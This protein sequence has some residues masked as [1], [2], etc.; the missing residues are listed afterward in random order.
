[1]L[2]AGAGV[3][4]AVQPTHPAVPYQCLRI[5]LN[6]KPPPN[7]KKHVVSPFSILCLIC[8]CMRSAL[9]MRSTTPK[10]IDTISN[11]M[12]VAIPLHMVQTSH[13]PR[14]HHSLEGAVQQYLLD[15]PVMM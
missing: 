9:D 12:L 11:L 13:S 8:Q 7:E 5:P 3:Q 14:P 15:R 1:M 4:G 6:P 10:G 2:K